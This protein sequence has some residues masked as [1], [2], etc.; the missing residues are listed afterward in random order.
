MQ[1]AADRRLVRAGLTYQTWIWQSTKDAVEAMRVGKLGCH[2]S[3]PTEA[4]VWI[5]CFGLEARGF[6]SHI[7][8]SVLCERVNQ[9]RRQ[10][11]A[12]K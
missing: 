7:C 8:G 6:R 12:S 2:C 5:V 11:V 10:R 3:R 1:R 9:Y 4:I